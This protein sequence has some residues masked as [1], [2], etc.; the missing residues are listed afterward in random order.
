MDQ[1]AYQRVSGRGSRDVHKRWSAISRHLP[2]G[3]FTSLDVGC[4]EGWMTEQLA[5]YGEAV[6]IDDSGRPNDPSDWRLIRAT[7]D[8]SLLA[9]LGRFDVTLALSILHHMKDGVAAFDLLRGMSGRLFVEI[10]H[11]NE[12]GV[13]NACDLTPVVKVLESDGVPI[14]ESPGYDRRY[15]RTVWLL[16]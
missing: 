13:A 16:K 3:P 15:R 12:R 5:K 9:S 4:A 1:H 6:G 10:P 14:V 11:P 7:A 2:E 8:V